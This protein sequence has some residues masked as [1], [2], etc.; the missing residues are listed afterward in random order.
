[1]VEIK[2]P[3]ARHALLWTWLMPLV[4]IIVLPAFLPASS[5]RVDPEELRMFSDTLGQD[6]AGVTRQ[7]DAIFTAMFVR[8]GV[9]EAV[10][11]FFHTVG[12]PLQQGTAKASRDFN[13]GYAQCLFLMLYRAIWRLCGILSITAGIVVGIGLPTLL[14]GLM[15]RARKA[16]NF[17]MHN[18]VYFWTAGHTVVMLIGATLFLPLLPLQLSLPIL[19]GTL[20][21]LFAVVWVT[22][23]NFQTGL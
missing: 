4:A 18:P 14:D 5:F 15:I 21:L 11:E 1:M 3:Y 17:E 13:T 9:Y 20:G 19:F 22:A 23:A 2:N 8:T 7:A 12:A 16:Y 6:I 10:T